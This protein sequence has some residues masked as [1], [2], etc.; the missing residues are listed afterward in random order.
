MVSDPT[1]VANLF[2]QPREPR[3]R[4]RLARDLA[5]AVIRWAQV[6]DL[7]LAANNPAAFH[8]RHGRSISSVARESGYVRLPERRKRRPAGRV[9]VA[10][11]PEATQTNGPDRRWTT[12]PQA[13]KKKAIR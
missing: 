11:V 6:P 1:E 12:Q 2:T 7:A 13:L 3:A 5:A 10:E 4:H 9:A 8:A